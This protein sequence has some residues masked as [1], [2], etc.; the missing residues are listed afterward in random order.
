MTKLR[1]GKYICTGGRVVARRD[2]FDEYYRLKHFE[3]TIDCWKI[4]REK[5]TVTGRPTIPHNC[6]CFL[7]KLALKL[8]RNLTSTMIS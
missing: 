5:N 1:P 4:L 7:V 6:D 3:T 2:L 8:R